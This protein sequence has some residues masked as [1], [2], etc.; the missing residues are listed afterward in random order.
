MSPTHDPVVQE[1]MDHMRLRN[2]M[3][4][5][6]RSIDRRDYETLRRIFTPDSYFEFNVTVKRNGFEEILS[7]IKSLERNR[8]TQH[9]LGNTYIEL[10]GDSAY[11]ETYGEAHHLT[12]VDDNNEI[13]RVFGV[14][15]MATVVR[16]K[17]E[18]LIKQIIEEADWRRD[19]VCFAAKR[20]KNTLS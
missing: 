8:A 19:E 5:Y 17:G 2:L 10:Q 3:P 18:W 7:M 12:P 15:Y 6:A 20:F 16:V 11:V 13:D 9:F 4:T 14:R 1:L